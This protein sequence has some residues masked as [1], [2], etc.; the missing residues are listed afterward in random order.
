MSYIT[1]RASYDAARDKPYPC[2]KCVLKL[3][4]WKVAPGKVD[5]PADAIHD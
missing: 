5:D 2:G 4:G 1:Q 3:R